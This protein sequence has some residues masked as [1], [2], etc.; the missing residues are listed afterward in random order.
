MIWS[1]KVKQLRQL[2]CWSRCSTLFKSFVHVFTN[3]IRPFHSLQQVASI[4]TCRSTYLRATLVALDISRALFVRFVLPGR[5]DYDSCRSGSP[6]RCC[7]VVHVMSVFA[8]PFG[9]GA[10]SLAYVH[11]FAICCINQLL[12]F[13]IPAIVDLNRDPILWVCNVFWSADALAESTVSPAWLGDLCFFYWF[14]PSNCN[15]GVFMILAVE[16]SVSNR[17]KGLLSIVGTVD[18]CGCQLHTKIISRLS[19]LYVGPLTRMHVE[20]W[21]HLGSYDWDDRLRT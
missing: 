21:Q 3:V 15:H 2:I 18:R 16:T 7:S 9:K 11:F 10:S 20:V 8:K 4:V 5:Q 6:A 19:H 13:T 14:W 17:W 1:N 12:R